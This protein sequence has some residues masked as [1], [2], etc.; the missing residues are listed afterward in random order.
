MIREG[1]DHL[2]RVAAQ[3]EICS[4]TSAGSQSQG[5][6]M[7]CI[8]RQHDIRLTAGLWKNEE[9]LHYLYRPS[10]HTLTCKKFH[11]LSRWPQ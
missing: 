10:P 3:T 9:M 7:L 11:L 2:N 5:G 4:H 1:L 6:I 8:E